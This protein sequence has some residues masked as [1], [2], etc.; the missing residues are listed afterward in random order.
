MHSP[1]T[2]RALSPI[3]PGLVLAALKLALMPAAYS[4]AGGVLG[5]RVPAA[6]LSFLGS[7]P[8]S[9]SV[10]SLALV[11]GL[12]PRVL[13]PPAASN[14]PSTLSPRT[15]PHP[16]ARRLPRLRSLLRTPG[17]AAASAAW[18]L[19]AAS[20]PRRALPP[21]TTMVRLP[22]A[23]PLVPL[24]LLASTGLAVAPV[25]AHPAAAPAAAALRGGLALVGAAS[26]ALS[27][28][29][30]P[31]AAPATADAAAARKGRAKSPARGK[32]AD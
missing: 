18:T 23:G 31:A 10:Y 8:A 25:V 29:A 26:A 15:A 9:A 3:P 17:R 28:R 2:L 19:A 5:S 1:C 32:K 16:P 14:T 11:A 7:L 6:F 30:A 20:A 27:L 4:V 13:G 21:K 12:S 24:T 22:L